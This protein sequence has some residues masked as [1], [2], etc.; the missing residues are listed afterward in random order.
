MD[1]SN[2]SCNRET[3]EKSD[4]ELVVDDAGDGEDD[5]DATTSKSQQPQPKGQSLDD[6]QRSGIEVS[7]Q[8]RLRSL[9]V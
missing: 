3:V 2:L 4:Q 5:G 9:C 8:L 1:F 6:E 7:A